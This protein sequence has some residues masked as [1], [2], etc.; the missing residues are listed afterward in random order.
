L[1]Q[2]AKAASRHARRFPSPAPRVRDSAHRA[3]V[4]VAWSPANEG[5]PSGSPPTEIELVAELEATSSPKWTCRQSLES[6]WVEALSSSR[7]SE[8]V[9]TAMLD[10]D[11]PAKHLVLELAELLTFKLAATHPLIRVR[12]LPSAGDRRTSQRSA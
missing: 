6:G 2:F 5:G 9:L 8:I 7:C 11:Q 4:V 12:F 10:D 3:R 1:T